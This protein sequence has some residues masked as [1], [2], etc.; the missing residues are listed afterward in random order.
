MLWASLLSLLVQL[1][2]V[3]VVWLVAQGLGLGISFSYLAVVVPLGTLVTLLPLSLGGVGLRE[4]AM[5]VLLAPLGVAEAQ[6]VTV[7]VLSYAVQIT[8]SLLGLGVY[9]FGRYPRFALPTAKGQGE[10]DA[11][12]EGRSDAEPVR[13]NP[14]Q[15]RMRQSATAA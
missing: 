5:V 12:G 11:S 9:L 13:G 3:L 8:V 6:A 4:V 2:N 7:S 10:G 15:G 14:D 1:A